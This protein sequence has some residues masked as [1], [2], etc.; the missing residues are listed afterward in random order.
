LDI[1][2]ESRHARGLLFSP[3]RSAETMFQD[4]GSFGAFATWR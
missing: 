3:G 2:V 4:E 1:A